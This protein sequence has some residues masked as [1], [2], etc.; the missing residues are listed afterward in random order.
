MPPVA[1][2]H[3][4]KENGILPKKHHHNS[5]INLRTRIIQ[6]LEFMMDQV[7]GL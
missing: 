1:S 4:Y 3:I 7:T 6:R 2:G 5:V